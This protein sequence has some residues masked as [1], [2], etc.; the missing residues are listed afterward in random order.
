MFP[1]APGAPVPDAVTVTVST[2]SAVLPAQLESVAV[3]VN[4]YVPSVVV[5]F[6]SIVHVSLPVEVTMKPVAPPVSSAQSMSPRCPPVASKVSCWEGLFH[7]I[8]VPEPL[9]LDTAKSLVTSRENVS[10]SVLGPPSPGSVESST[11]T[12]MV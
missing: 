3:S 4:V 2:M 6:F 9:V 12:P 7:V 1:V 11:C 5:P 8:S 10:E